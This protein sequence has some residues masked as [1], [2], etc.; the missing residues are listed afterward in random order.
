[1]M[2]TR[3]SLPPPRVT[4][5]TPMRSESY[6]STI[7]V[8]DRVLNYIEA[9]DGEISLSK[10]AADLGLSLSELQDAIGRLRSS[11]FLGLQGEHPSPPGLTQPSSQKACVHCSRLLEANARFCTDCGAEQP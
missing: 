6:P 10:A 5:T 8:D 11:G 3:A 1:M 4:V 9:H 2:R 7:S